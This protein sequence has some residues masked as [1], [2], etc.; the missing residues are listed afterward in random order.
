MDN[1]NN[2]DLEQMK[3][4]ILSARNQNELIEAMQ[5]YN[6]W[7]NEPTT[8]KISV[9]SLQNNF[10]FSPSRE[11]AIKTLT[12]KK[13]NQIKTHRERIGYST[14]ESRFMDKLNMARKKGLSSKDLEELKKMGLEKL[15]ED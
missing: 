5:K 3:Q 13:W 11:R 9:G 10:D 2:K 1:E 15:L 4:D 12:F 6:R 14:E 7:L 8:G